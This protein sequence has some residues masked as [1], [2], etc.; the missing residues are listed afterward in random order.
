MIHATAKTG[1]T[2]PATQKIS[3]KLLG[4]SV[5]NWNLV[6]H[7]FSTAT[8]P[9]KSTDGFS[10]TLH[11]KLKDMNKLWALSWWEFVIRENT[12]I[13]QLS[14]I[15]FYL[16]AF[17]FSIFSLKFDFLLTERVKIGK[18]ARKYAISRKFLWNVIKDWKKILKFAYLK[19]WKQ[20]FFH[21]FG[22]KTKQ[23]IWEN[24]RASLASGYFAQR[25]L[26]LSFWLDGVEQGRMESN[27]WVEV[28]NFQ[29]R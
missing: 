3:T 13:F 2:L 27:P 21:D 22:I 8:S 1:K 29:N 15:A 11:Q 23:R 24:W 4:K 19:F 6:S 10:L 26:Y 25:Y 28:N 16:P 9:S 5:R 20:I 17:H 18:L 7:K 14:K 12:W